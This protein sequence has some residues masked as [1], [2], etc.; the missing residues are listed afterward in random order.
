MSVINDFE[1]ADIQHK[2]PAEEHLFDRW[3]N[4]R[5]G[6]DFIRDGIVDVPTFNS[7]SPRIVFVLKDTDG[8]RFDLR[9]FLFVGAWNGKSGFRDGSHTWGP[10]RRVLEKLAHSTG[11]AF[12]VDKHK[13]LR[14]IAAI[15]V[16]KE[17]GGVQCPDW[18]LA[19]ASERDGDYI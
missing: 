4:D 17:A 3:T 6:V 19:E 16:K 18:K 5:P 11:W 14:A 8:G 9:E 12:P 1:T 13:S 15:N 10:I 2:S 7:M